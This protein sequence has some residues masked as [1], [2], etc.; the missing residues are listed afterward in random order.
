MGFSVVSL[1]EIFY[2]LTLRPYCTSR[3]N[4][5]R[6]QELSDTTDTDNSPSPSRNN[7][8]VNQFRRR[9]FKNNYISHGIG[10]ESFKTKR[11]FNYNRNM[12]SYNNNNYNT[13][14]LKRNGSMTV[15]KHNENLN[16]YLNHSDGGYNGPKYIYCE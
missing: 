14:Q 16:F 6:R 10:G 3:K 11:N 9:G 7:N 1:V 4:R 2:F 5:H 12:V 13:S 15:K 8:S